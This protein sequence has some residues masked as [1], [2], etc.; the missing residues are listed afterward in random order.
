MAQLKLSY[1]QKLSGMDA[2]A[3]AADSATQ[4]AKAKLIDANTRLSDL[5]AQFARSVRRDPKVLAARQDMQDA[6]VTRVAAA[7]LL[8]GAYDAREIALEYAYWLHQ[9][10]PYTY[11][12]NPTYYDPYYSVSYPSYYGSGYGYG[13]GTT[14]TGTNLGA[15]PF[16]RGGRNSR[17]VFVR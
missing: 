2:D 12:Y 5:R 3:L 13:V 16:F 15:D 14:Y 10:D 17:N 4:D 9:H 11:R 7:A 8:D 1:G 6:K